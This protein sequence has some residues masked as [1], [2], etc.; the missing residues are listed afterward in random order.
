MPGNFV[1]SEALFLEEARS[2]EALLVE[3]P[4][5]S[6]AVT[7]GTL[8]GRLT[9]GGLGG[10]VA[11]P[12]YA[13]GLDIPLD[14]VGVRESARLVDLCLHIDSEWSP[15]GCEGAAFW[16][17]ALPWREN[18]GTVGTSS[19]EVDV[20]PVCCEIIVAPPARVSRG[21]GA[22]K[23]DSPRWMLAGFVGGDTVGVA[24]DGEFVS[25]L[26]AKRMRS[27]LGRRCGSWRQ[28]LSISFLLL[29]AQVDWRFGG[30]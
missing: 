14:M 26:T 13:A 27:K 20:P 10:A 2:I 9:S 8:S 12:C 5:T 19:V 30:S 21:I 11:T 29:E 7:G 23:P 4:R 28:Q 15:K 22:G 18:R 1:S 25:F 6:A 24:E 16:E 3:R 17:G